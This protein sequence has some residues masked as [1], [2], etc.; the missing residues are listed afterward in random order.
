MNASETEG[1][2]D[3]PSLT[4]DDLSP[5]VNGLPGTTPLQAPFASTF[6]QDK[7]SNCFSHVE[8]LTFTRNFLKSPYIRQDLAE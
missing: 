7:V 8:Y 3:N 1:C 4:N 5:I 2:N 6:T